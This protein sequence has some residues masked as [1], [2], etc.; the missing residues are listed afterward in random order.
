[1]FHSTLL[2]YRAV[3]TAAAVALAI[4]STSMAEVEYELTILPTLPGGTNC[5]AGDI[6]DAGVVVGESA[7]P[8]TAYLNAVSWIDGKAI[9]LTGLGI[10]GATA[11]GINNSGMIV[12]MSDEFNINAYRWA[13][14]VIEQLDTPNSCCSEAHAVNATGIICGR[15][16]LNGI[17]SNS[18]ALW[19]DGAWQALDSSKHSSIAYDIN[20]NMQVVGSTYFSSSMSS[21][22]LW[23][24][25]VMT[26][27]TTPSEPPSHVWAYAIN[28]D[29][30]VVGYGSHRGILWEEGNVFELP[31]LPGGTLSS[32]KDVN[33]QGTIIGYSY[34]DGFSSKH[35]CRWLE[36]Q[37]ADL[38]DLVD[39]GD[40]ILIEATAIN[41]NG[42]IVGMAFSS[43]KNSGHA[44]ILTPITQPCP[45]DLSGD[46]VV[47][48][49]DL[50]TVIADWG[51]PWD[52]EDLLDVIGNWGPCP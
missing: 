47:D 1:M 46:G 17:S 37:V 40:W 28:E 33:N 5:R 42:Q 50:L 22:F 36:G 27:L 52:V 30:A 3:F 41:N 13:G 25:G 15:I 6:N 11:N 31:P 29:G 32:A 34:G 16:S 49:Q 10:S 43:S 4:I 45:G 9:D 14:G 20:D 44:Y 26:E 12:G 23:E 51:N 2:P 7:I 38:N 35:A 48:V 24:N 8:G 19:I 39:G 21:G 18:A